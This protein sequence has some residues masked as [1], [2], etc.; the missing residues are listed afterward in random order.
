[1]LVHCLTGGEKM[2]TIEVRKRGKDEEFNFEDVIKN[3]NVTHDNCFGG[4]VEFKWVPANNRDGG[5]Y[6][7]FRCKRCTVWTRIKEN[8]EQVKLIIIRTA[9]DGQERKLGDHVRVIQK[10]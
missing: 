5:R 6:W 8:E 2:F 10:T 3:V 9:I 7:S 1:M 4:K